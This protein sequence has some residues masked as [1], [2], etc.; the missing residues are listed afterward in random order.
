M[1][2]R[3]SPLARRIRRTNEQVGGAKVLLLKSEGFPD[4]SLDAVAVGRSGDM[5]AGDQDS[6]TRLTRTTPLSQQTQA[7]FGMGLLIGQAGRQIL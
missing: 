6:E 7:F 3:I 4:A 2:E 5:L 1:V